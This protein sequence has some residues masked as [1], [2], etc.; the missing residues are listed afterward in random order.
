MKRG[1]LILALAI[2][3]EC[4]AYWAGRARQDPGRRE[5]TSM[6]DAL[7]ELEWLRQ[8][9]KLSS[10]QLAKVRELHAAYRPQCDGMCR[11]IAEARARM[12][13]ISRACREV[14]PEL[15]AAVKD[16]ADLLADCQA[17]MLEHLYRTAAV[18]DER[19][20]ARYLETTLPFAL[21]MPSAAP[22]DHHGH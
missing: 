9:L 10:G 8:D 12:N 16:H 17:A 1:I 7:P 4:V 21:D 22:G 13:R 20:A 14:T 19:Q 18:L 6:M 2:A 5:T 11:R 3:A 15:K